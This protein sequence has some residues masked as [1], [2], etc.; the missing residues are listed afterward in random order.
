MNTQKTACFTCEGNEEY[1]G[2]KCTC[3]AGYFLDS[4]GK[5]SKVVIPTCLNNEYYHSEKK[6]CFC[7]EGFEKIK[8]VCTKIP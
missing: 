4:N 6:A 3:K 1:D 5:C 8:G 2:I 7:K